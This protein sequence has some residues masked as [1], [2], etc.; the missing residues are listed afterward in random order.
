MRHKKSLYSILLL[1]S[2]VVGLFLF[3][4]HDPQPDI[5]SEEHMKCYELSNSKIYV[6]CEILPND[7][8][9]NG[10]KVGKM[11]EHIPRQDQIITL[12]QHSIIDRTTMNLHLAS[13][14]PTDDQSIVDHYFTFIMGGFGN[15]DSLISSNLEYCV[16][17]SETI[18]LILSSCVWLPSDNNVF[19]GLCSIETE[20]C[21]AY[22]LSQGFV[23]NTVLTFSN[24]P[25]GLYRLYV[26]P[27]VPGAFSSGQFYGKIIIEP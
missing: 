19:I 12:E 10:G 21:Y 1:L 6:Q 7:W 20:T 16:S 5:L 17:N 9:P 27:E 3:S 11:V 24:L 4:S 18:S 15:P 25:N 22:P 8:S 13:P 14:V 23:N 26:A 2:C